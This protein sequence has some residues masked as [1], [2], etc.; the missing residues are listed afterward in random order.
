MTTPPLHFQTISELAQGIRRGDFSPLELTE[1]FLSRIDRLDGSLN[2]YRLVCREKALGEAKAF[3]TAL[4]AGRDFGPLHGIPYSAKDLFDVAGLPT[5]AGSSLLQENIA[6]EDATV[7]D[8]LARSGMVL[9]GKTNTVQLAYSG[10]GI[11]HDHGTPK[12]PWKKKHHAPG[13]SSSGSGVAVAAGLAP[14]A[15]GSDTGGSVRIPAALCGATGLKTTVGRISRAGVY[16]LSGSMD[17]VGPLARCAEDAALIY[18]AMQGEDLKDDT[19][20]GRS[21]HDVLSGLKDGVRGMRLAFPETSFWEEVD[22]EIEK[23]VRSCGDVF[24]GLGAHV[25]RMELPEAS[26]AWRLNSQGMII[27]AEAYANNKMLLE[28][29]YDR[30]DIVV[31][32]RMIKGRDVPAADYLQNMKEWQRLRSS[33]IRTLRHVDALLVPTTRIPALPIDEIDTDIETYTA[34]NIGYLRNTSIGNILNFCGLSV[35]CGFTSKG[36]PIGL[37]V[38]A[39]PFEE[40]IVL[41]AGYAFQQTTDWHRRTPELV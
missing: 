24:K 32:R 31:A 15:L 38:Y 18:Q 8:K 10:I 40:D 23:A 14:M 12:N 22:P 19:T 21:P 9:L 6:S 35:P 29:H 2:A 33:V 11:N 30:M 3:E 28:D 34:C 36:L 7:I 25:E 13:G 16:P 5:T 20:R 26:E 41:R 4:R 37:M 17:S 1:H 27:V 39:K